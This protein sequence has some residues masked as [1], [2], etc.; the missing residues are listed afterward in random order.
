MFRPPNPWIQGILSLV[1]E[2][3]NQDKL[4]LNLK[5]EIEMLY[6]NLNLSINDAKA[7]HTLAGHK[8]D[9][10]NNA[11]FA[12]DKVS[13]ASTRVHDSL[14]LAPDIPILRRAEVAQY[15]C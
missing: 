12:P 3:Y 5:F 1:A 10:T 8:R 11:D 13:P 9:P 7:S 6:R 15:M 14:Y 2:I 4:K